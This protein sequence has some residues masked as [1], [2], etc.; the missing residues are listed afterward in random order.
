MMRTPLFA[1]LVFLYVAVVHAAALRGQPDARADNDVT[2]PRRHEGMRP[3]LLGPLYSQRRT[4][5]G[6]DG[7]PVV[8]PRRHQRRR[9]RHV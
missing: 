2:H 6:G 9:H 7:A 8:V 5:D 4:T 1:F 3:R